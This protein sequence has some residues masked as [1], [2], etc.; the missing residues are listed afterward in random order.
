MVM[1]AKEAEVQFDLDGVVV[2]TPSQS[3]KLLNEISGKN[4]TKADIITYDWLPR[5]FAEYGIGKNE[6]FRPELARQAEPLPLAIPTLQYLDELY[7]G[8]INFATSR[9]SQYIQATREWFEQY[10]P[11]P[12]FADRLY[13]R[14]DESIGG[15]EFK[16]LISQAGNVKRAYE[17]CGETALKFD[18]RVILFRQQHNR[19]PKYMHL[20]VVEN[21]AEVM[22]LEINNFLA[23]Y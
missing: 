21:W 3:I 1:T 13:I 4:Y 15:D 19:Q 17:D 22:R 16:I 14:E 18:S 6:W 20:P 9:P 2:D 8:R 7:S 5:L 23:R 10:Y 11:R 12:L